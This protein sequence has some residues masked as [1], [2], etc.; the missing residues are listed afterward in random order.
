MKQLAKKMWMTSACITAL[1]LFGCAAQPLGTPSIES[2]MEKMGQ[3]IGAA[4]KSTTMTE[5]SQNV[6]VFSDNAAHAAQNKYSGTAAEQ[7]L[8]VEG[9]LQLRAGINEVNRHV[10][11]NDLDS[12]KKALSALL[13]IRNKYHATLKK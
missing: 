3:S 7:A 6:K 10:A 5:F 2:S 12:A 1:G 8:Y 9:M 11:A 4:M 13:P